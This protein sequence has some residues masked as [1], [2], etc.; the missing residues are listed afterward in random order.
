MKKP[1]L[2]LAAAGLLSFQALAGEIRVGAFPT[3][4]VQILE[5]I[6]PALKEQGVDLQIVSITDGIQTNVAVAEGSLDANYFQHKPYLDYM[7]EAHSLPLVSIGGVHVEPMGIYSATVKDIDDLKEGAVIAV[8][9]D[10]T[11]TARTLLL[12]QKHGLIRLK[13]PESI[14]STVHDIVENKRNF[15]FIELD[16]M[17]IAVSLDDF[18]AAGILTNVALNAGLSPLKDAIVL[19]G[20]DSPYANVIAVTRDR[21]GEED[22]KKLLGA[23][24]SEEVRQ[25]ILEE[26]KGAV[27]PAF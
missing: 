15:K 19:E 14:N 4:H 8:N 11:N 23:L 10:P 2:L 5:F 17:L 21:Q 24:R 6:K 22:F 12:L 18:D 25:F 27:V 16:P 3:P 13:N 9:N 20:K 1:F 7:A 26:F